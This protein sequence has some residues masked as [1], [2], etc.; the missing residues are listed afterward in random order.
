MYAIMCALT[1][2]HRVTGRKFNIFSDSMS[3][4]EAVNGF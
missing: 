1:S 4:L 3:S 2:I